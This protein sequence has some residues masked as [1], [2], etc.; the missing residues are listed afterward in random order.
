MHTRLYDRRASGN[1][2][3]R[4]TLAEQLARQKEE[5]ELK[6]CTFKPKIN[7]NI[8]VPSDRNMIAKPSYA[9]RFS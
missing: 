8:N 3:A 1:L 9:K 4:P 5:D 2:K 6:E 7:S